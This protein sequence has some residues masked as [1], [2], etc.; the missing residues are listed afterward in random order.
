MPTTLSVGKIN[1]FEGHKDCIYSI[2]SGKYEEEFYTGAGDGWVVYW[3]QKNREKGQL[4]A[5]FPTSIYA[6]RYFPD[7]NQILVGLSRGGYYFLDLE[8]K[9]PYADFQ[10]DHG[11]FDFKQIPNTTIMVVAGEKGHVHIVDF[12]QMKE[13][14]SFKPSNGNAR[15]INFSPDAEHFAIGFS[16]EYI[17]I[18]NSN[19]FDMEKAFHAHEKSAF[20]V[21]FTPDGRFLLS[22]G[23]DAQLKIWDRK[24]DYDLYLKIPAHYFTINDIVTSPCGSWFATGSRDNTAKIW[25]AKS[26]ELYKVIDLEK[27]AGHRHSINEML[28]SNYKDYLLTASDDKTIKAWAISD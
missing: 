1:E 16:D 17:R 13:L 24:S 2:T 12:D 14:H 26:F 9:K 19:T 21:A 23:R 11:V 4:I 20:S 25:D 7:R 18:F 5:T 22:G 10:K 8:S 28:W 27:L 3:N 6:L 15:K